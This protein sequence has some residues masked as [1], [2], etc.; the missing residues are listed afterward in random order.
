MFDYGMRPPGFR[1][2]DEISL[3][4]VRLQVSQI[5]RSID[6]YE[7]VVGLR[8]LERASGSA[9]LAPHA[10]DRPL[11]ALDELR[12]A[13]PAPRRGAFGLY[14]FA[15]LL[16]ARADLGRFAAHLSRS[17]AQAG[18]ADHA[19]SQSFYLTDPDGLGIEVYADRPRSEWRQRGRELV[20]TVDPL[21]VAGLIDA[22]GDEPWRGLPS[23]SKIGHIHLHVGDLVR[24][25]AFYHG[26]LG[27]DKIVWTFPGAL[28]FSVGGY[29]H[30]LGTNTWSAGPAAAEDQAR[31]LEW[32][33]VLPH[34]RDVAAA[35]ASLEAGGY[36]V[37]QMDDIN[38]RATA[39]DPWGTRFSLVSKA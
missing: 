24:A 30:H 2:P 8:V 36:T 15:L 11:V 4:V 27:F 1:L 17:G 12:N 37:Q 33:I 23:G 28:F 38:Y 32:E 31:L 20:M 19:V 26:A 18:S 13:R 35:A 3:G 22:G 34:G 9:L 6:Y 7:R 29:H 5:A 10:D 16:P 21:D 14:H 39:A 25:E